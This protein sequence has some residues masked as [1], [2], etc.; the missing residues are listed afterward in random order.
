MNAPSVDNWTQTKNSQFS[1]IP[2]PDLVIFFLFF[3]FLL[4]LHSVQYHISCA[5]LY[6]DWQF[7]I[8]V[9]FVFGTKINNRINV[10]V[11][12]FFRPK[13]RN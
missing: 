5:K 1:K 11:Y 10:Q 4:F 12:V 7:A 9:A 13:Y 6:L 2:N 3:F 8:S